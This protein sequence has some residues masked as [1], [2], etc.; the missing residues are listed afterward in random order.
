V[1]LEIIA[2]ANDLVD[3]GERPDGSSG[4]SRFLTLKHV[5]QM[6]SKR[7]KHAPARENP[8]DTYPQ[9]LLGAMG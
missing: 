4:T 8:E 5:K 3:C 6:V 7:G 1:F 9:T 2:S